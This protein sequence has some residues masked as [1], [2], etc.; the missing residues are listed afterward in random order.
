MKRG[1]SVLLVL[2]LGALLAAWQIGD[3]ELLHKYYAAD[4]MVVS[5]AWEPPLMGWAN[6]L[7][8]Y[9]S[10]RERMQGGRMDR[11]N[12]LIATRG[13][14]GWAVYQWDFG[15][16]VDG[17]QVGARGHTTLVLEKRGDHAVGRVRLRRISSCDDTCGKIGAASW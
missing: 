7:K 12:T 3:T 9:Q 5:G 2:F 15:A 17:R 11:R 8:A 6:F 10:Q 14:I 16:M 13:N 4:V 1:G